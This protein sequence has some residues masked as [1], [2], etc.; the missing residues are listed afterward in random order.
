[1]I[2]AKSKILQVIW[3]VLFISC[4]IY[5]IIQI[6]DTLI[7]FSSF[8]GLRFYFKKLKSFEYFYFYKKLFSPT[9]YCGKI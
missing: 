4:A 1:M 9:K 3:F 2:K 5:C 6:I 7:L 8:Q